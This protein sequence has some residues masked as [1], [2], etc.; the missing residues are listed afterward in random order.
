MREFKANSAGFTLIELMVVIAI[1][2]ILLTVGVPMMRSTTANSEADSVRQTLELDINFARNKAITFAEN[3]IITPA[4]SGFD[5]G[6]TINLKASGDLIRARDAYDDDVDITSAV[7]ND[8]TP[9]EFDVEGRSITD[10]ALTIKVDGCT[11]NRVRIL[12]LNKIGQLIVT[13]AACS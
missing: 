3:V 11:G 10:G 4:A 12:T 6:W 5:G 1:A 7:F 13:E 2:A 8:A 9:I